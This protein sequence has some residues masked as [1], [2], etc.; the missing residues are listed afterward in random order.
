MIKIAVDLAQDNF[1][2]SQEMKH[3]MEQALDL[4]AV[5]WGAMLVRARSQ[6]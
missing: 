6:S 5:F 2:K 1:Q 4:R 3:G